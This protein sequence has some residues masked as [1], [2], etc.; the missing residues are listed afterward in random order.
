M[1]DHINEPLDEKQLALDI[2][3]GKVFTDRHITGDNDL[4]TVFMVLV[5]MDKEAMDKMTTE[6][7]P[8]GTIYEY[9]DK[10]GPMAVNGL[11]C[12][13]S[14]RMLNTEQSNRVWGM[15]RE[16]KAAVD[17]IGTTNAVS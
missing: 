8:N 3:K 17:A 4:A 2:F 10:A 12:F 14:L 15:Y 9:L 6:L 11:P 5:F 1:S 13:F 7:G 16:M